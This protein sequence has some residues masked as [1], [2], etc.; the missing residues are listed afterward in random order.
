MLLAQQFVNGLMLGS[1]YALVAVAFTL[2]IGVLNFLNFSIPGIFMLG[3]MFTWI[4]LKS[5]LP[6]GLVVL[7]ALVIGA[8]ASLLVERSSYRQMM[9]SDHFIPLVSSMGFLILYEN[10]VLIFWGSDIQVVNSP[11]RDVSV[12]VFG[13][14]I[15]IPQLAGLAL[16]VTMAYVLTRILYG[17]ST[18]RGLR[19]IAENP[20]SAIMLGVHVFRIVPVVFLFSGLFTA[21]AGV[22]FAL[23]YTQVHPFMGE[24][25]A[26]KG[27]SAM[28]IGG[29]GSVWGAIVGGLLIGVA[30]ILSISSFGSDFVDIAVYGLLLVIL[31][32]RPEGLFGGSALGRERL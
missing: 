4:F 5:G 25:V 8:A 20:D 1:I 27:I 11:F 6:L 28:V 26:L 24:E 23:N 3:G 18:G 12:T 10:L 22:I 21:L 17:T 2:T 7:L 31:V 9:G 13:L 29:M 32:I 15:S 19:A 30:E 14:I 16:A